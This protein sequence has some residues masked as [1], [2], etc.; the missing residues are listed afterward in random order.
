MSWL[1]GVEIS[2]PRWETKDSRCYYCI[3]LR[4]PRDRRTRKSENVFWSAS[5]TYSDFR[6]FRKELKTL[7]KVDAQVTSEE[8]RA[9]IDQPKVA[10]FFSTDGPQ[11]LTLDEKD[12]GSACCHCNGNHCPFREMYH[13]LKSVPFPSRILSILPYRSKAQIDSRRLALQKFL[14]SVHQ[15]CM[16]IPRATL[17]RIDLYEQCDV[18]LLF[19]SFIGF[20][21]N[22]RSR[23]LTRSPVSLAA[24]KDSLE[25]H[26]SFS[27]S[28]P[29]GVIRTRSVGIESPN[30][31]N[32]I[33]I[34]EFEDAEH[35][36]ALTAWEN[37]LES[38][39]VGV[40]VVDDTV[41]MLEHPSQQIVLERRLLDSTELYDFS[42]VDDQSFSNQQAP[43]QLNSGLSNVEPERSAAHDQIL[44][45][46][47]RLP[48]LRVRSASVKKTKAY[49]EELVHYLLLQFPQNH[50]TAELQHHESL[51]H[52]SQTRQ[53]ELAFYV[54]CQ[55][56]NLNAV[57]LFLSRGT[58]PNTMIQNDQSSAL[59][60]ACVNGNCDIVALLL[61]CQ[62]LDLNWCDNRG[63][64]ALM[65]A[66]ECMQD[67]IVRLVLEA[68]ANVS[69]SCSKGITVFHRAATIE[70]IAI[71]KMLFAYH[72]NIT[73]TQD[74]AGNT[75]LHLAAQWGRFEQSALL[76]AHGVDGTIRNHEGDSA[77]DLAIATSHWRIASLFSE[78]THRMNLTI[79]R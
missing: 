12:I 32:Q 22:L 63:Q 64:T 77:W 54:A 39:H 69:F 17:Q 15:F 25:A 49:F 16:S 5:R 18:L 67:E 52:Q 21:E 72:P 43:N 70:S 45:E 44:C 41:P 26:F 79:R 1:R 51:F 4:T 23:L 31:G 35:T 74:P 24:W 71:M 19:S 78:E 47:R 3:R 10:D 68:G 60:V 65:V 36:E 2:V 37:D 40:A 75:P 30:T 13:S 28:S 29:S 50:L 59:I 34:G 61:T 33:E 14:V 76:L 11:Y 42:D 56:G 53:W 20:D 6:N 46:L 57:K 62:E 38:A 27:T 48:R 7:T 8:L 55:V 66:V 9:S 73:L 58:D